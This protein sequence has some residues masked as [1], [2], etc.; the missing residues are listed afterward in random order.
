MKKSGGK[1]KEGCK[2]EGNEQR[3]GQ[4]L[5]LARCQIRVGGWG[6]HRVRQRGGG[7]LCSFETH[8][9]AGPVLFT[10]LQLSSARVLFRVRAFQKVLKEPLSPLNYH[11]HT[12]CLLSSLSLPPLHQTQE[13]R[14]GTE[15]GAGRMASIT[16]INLKRCWRVESTFMRK[17][18]LG[19]FSPCYLVR[20][21][22]GGRNE[23]GFQAK[24]EAE[25]L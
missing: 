14:R 21:L 25:D 4:I 15:T 17:D 16:N 23:L 6:W 7:C 12:L 10:A 11:F 9:C 13:Q 3:L 24:G 18:N 19:F 1:K 20:G 22:F 8:L 5:G 2:E